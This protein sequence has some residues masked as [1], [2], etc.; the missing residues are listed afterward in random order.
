MWGLCLQLVCLDTI[1]RIIIQIP[2]ALHINCSCH[3]P[4]STSNRF[5]HCVGGEVTFWLVCQ[6]FGLVLNSAVSSI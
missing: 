6:Q 1:I 5:A 4:R 3:T 2:I